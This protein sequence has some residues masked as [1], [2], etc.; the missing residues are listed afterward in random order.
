M[1]DS[2]EDELIKVEEGN[3]IDSERLGDNTKQDGALLNSQEG[4]PHWINKVGPIRA[5]RLED[6]KSSYDNE[7]YK[8][9]SSPALHFRPLNQKKQAGD[10][11]NIHGEFKRIFNNISK[12]ATPLNQVPPVKQSSAS[13]QDRKF[14]IQ[15]TVIKARSPNKLFQNSCLSNLNQRKDN[16]KGRLFSGIN[17]PSNSTLSKM[18]AQ[19]YQTTA[20]SKKYIS[21]LQNKFSAPFNSSLSKHTTVQ[22]FKRKALGCAEPKS[23]AIFRLSENDKRPSEY[24]T[25]KPVYDKHKPLDRA[26]VSVYDRPKTDS[27]SIVASL[28]PMSP[29]PTQLNT[30]SRKQKQQL[31]FNQT[32]KALD[33]RRANSPPGIRLKTAQTPV[34]RMKSV[35]KLVPP[36]NYSQKR[37]AGLRERFQSPGTTIRANRDKFTSFDGQRSSPLNADEAMRSSPFQKSTALESLKSTIKFHNNTQEGSIMEKLLTEYEEQQKKHCLK[38]NLNKRLHESTTAGQSYS[39][40]KLPNVPKET[41]ESSSSSSGDEEDSSAESEQLSK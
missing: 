24:S 31:T 38:V 16:L 1:A 6:S 41:Q 14:P 33:I 27:Q 40:K 9:R 15:N 17:E 2:Q 10:S 20:S 8:E 35:E 28:R 37:V 32:M 18:M 30:T 39:Q 13:R 25:M 4:S 36:M 3:L 29:K 22:S 11:S 21:T 23:Q 26:A 19:S 34:A 5:S 12:E 7:T